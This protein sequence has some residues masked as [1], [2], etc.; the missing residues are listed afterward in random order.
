VASLKK[1]VTAPG[2]IVMAAIGWLAREDKLAFDTAGRTV[3][4]SLR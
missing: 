3:K 1:E 4:I 2:E